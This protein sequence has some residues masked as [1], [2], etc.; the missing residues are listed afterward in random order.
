MTPKLT[1]TYHQDTNHGWV[2]VPKRIYNALPYRASKY[3]YQSD[4]T[5]F[6]EHDYDFPLFEELAK[7]KGHNFE[8]YEK[9]HG[10]DCFVRYLE[11]L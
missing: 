8:L 11:R 7:E 1:L 3:S 4:E 10:E 6:L 2:A 5:V 9:H